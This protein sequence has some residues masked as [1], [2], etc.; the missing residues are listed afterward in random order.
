M[1]P[2]DKVHTLL[3]EVLHNTKLD[4]Q[5][6]H[7]INILAFTLVDPISVKI[8]SRSVKALQNWK[9]SIKALSKQLRKLTIITKQLIAIIIVSLVNVTINK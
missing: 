6:S 8:L 2:L 3:K 9:I 1:L 5:V 4:D 7:Y